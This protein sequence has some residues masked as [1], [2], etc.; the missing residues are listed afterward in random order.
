MPNIRLLQESLR[1]EWDVYEEEMEAGEIQPADPQVIC[2]QKGRSQLS[3]RIELS[4][5]FCC[6]YCHTTSSSPLP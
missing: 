3:T 1:N 4:D 2:I 5:L 6:R